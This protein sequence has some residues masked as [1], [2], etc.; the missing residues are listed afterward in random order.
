[1]IHARSRAARFPLRQL[2]W[3]KLLHSQRGRGRILKEGHQSHISPM[4]V[5]N[6]RLFAGG[7]WLT[8][9]VAVVAAHALVVQLGRRRRSMSLDLGQFGVVQGALLGLLGL[10]LALSFA[11][12]ADRFATR[13]ELIL[14]GA[15]AIGT[16]YL[17][18]DLLPPPH[19]DA[20]RE[21]LKS[22]VTTRVAFYDAGTDA[23]A[24]LAT[25][26]NS[27]QLHQAMWSAGMAGVRD[28]PA[29]TTVVVPALNDVIDLHAARVDALHRHLPTAV[30]LL[31]LLTA[32]LVSASVGFSTGL[33]GVR[34]V[35]GNIAFLL[36]TA[37][38]LSL[39]LDL[40]FPRAGI[41]RVGQLPLLE[42]QRG[43]NETPQAR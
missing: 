10:L 21:T 14:N 31:L 18:A 8:T 6:V 41:V 1:M 35:W 24:V 7:I 28:T 16:A 9:L 36:V 33:S 34:H 22:Y 25:I 39:T 13:R 38:V 4:T 27:E 15:N 37:A 5:E 40:D 11:A 17:R 43:L 19:A 32:M 20:L 2:P 30:V 12:A 3:R 26:A 42:L 23:R 29:A